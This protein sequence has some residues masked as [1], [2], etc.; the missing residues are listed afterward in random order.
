MNPLHWEDAFQRLHRDQDPNHQTVNNRIVDSTS[1][2]DVHWPYSRCSKYTDDEP[3]NRLLG[4]KLGSERFSFP[5]QNFYTNESELEE[6]DGEPMRMDEDDPVLPRMRKELREQEKQIL[7]KTF[8][9][10]LKTV[11]PFVETL[12]PA[13]P[14]NKRSDTY[15]IGRAHV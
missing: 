1:G 13:F 8:A 9:P 10:A 15:K 7:R 14:S 11:K 12:S 2:T 4:V 6:L 5:S 3:Q